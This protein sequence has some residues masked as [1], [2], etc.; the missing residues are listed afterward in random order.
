MPSAISDV[1]FDVDFDS[2]AAWRV[3]AGACVAAARGGG[4]VACA[5]YAAQSEAL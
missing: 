1:A 3:Y 5:S 4:D 2:S